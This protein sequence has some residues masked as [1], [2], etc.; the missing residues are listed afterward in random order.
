MRMKSGRNRWTLFLFLL[1]GMVF[2]SF[3]GFYLKQFSFLEWL[4]Y[5]QAFGITD[6]LTLSLGVLSMTI[7]FVMRINVGSV[8]GM[9]LGYVAYRYT[10]G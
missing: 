1:A 9:A 6:P 7:G 5:G 4:D 10:E 8:I 2:G 3:L